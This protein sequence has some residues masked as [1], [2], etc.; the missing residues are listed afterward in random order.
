MVVARLDNIVMELDEL[1][2]DL[3]K[4]YDDYSSKVKT[5]T[6]KKSKLWL[7]TDFNEVLGK[8]RP[9]VDEKKAYVSQQSLEEKMARDDAYYL[10]E[11]LKHK[12][13]ACHLKLKVYDE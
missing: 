4:A 1:I 8:G 11:Y 5:Y 2:E 12:I 7:Y 3:H 13:D 10:I 6:E 9:T